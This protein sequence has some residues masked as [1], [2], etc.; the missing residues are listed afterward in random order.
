LEKRLKDWES[1][2]AGWTIDAAKLRVVAKAKPA[3]S[4]RPTLVQ[5]SLASKG[6]LTQEEMNPLDGMTWEERFWFAFQAILELERDLEE[7]EVREEYFRCNTCRRE[8]GH[9]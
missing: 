8:S 5:P 4:D 7:L 1:A 2:N 9:L 6:G 3:T